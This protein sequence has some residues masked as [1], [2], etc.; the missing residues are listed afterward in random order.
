[1]GR[2]AIRT[3]AERR[4]SETPRGKFN[5][6]KGAKVGT[7]RC[8][9]LERHVDVVAPGDLHDSLERRAVE[10]VDRFDSDEELARRSCRLTAPRSSPMRTSGVSSSKSM[11][12][13]ARSMVGP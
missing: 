3:P 10:E 11:Y 4:F 1:L 13:G 7:D 9:V 2:A 5:K 8:V 6:P 12:A